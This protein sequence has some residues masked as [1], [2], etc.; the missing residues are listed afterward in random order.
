M[1]LGA[2][3]GTAWF[4]AQSGDPEPVAA[5]SPEA[6]V[7][8]AA[9]PEWSVPLAGHGS[10]DFTTGMAFASWLTDTTVIR[11]QKD[12]VLAYTLNTGKR[13]WGTPSPGDQLCGA[14]PEVSADAVAAIAY[15]TDG[16]CGQLAGLDTTTGKVTWKTVIASEKSSVSNSLAVPSIM[17]TADMAVVEVDNTLT[18][19]RL[20]DGGKA[21]T[22]SPPDSCY[23]QDANSAPDR[24][25]ILLDCHSGSNSVQVLH[26]TTGRVA[27]KYPIGDLPLTNGVLSARPIVIHRQIRGEDTFTVYASTGKVSEFSAGEADTRSLNSVALVQGGH[28][29][30][31]YAVHG[32]RLYLATKLEHMPDDGGGY[33]NKALA[34][35]IKTGRRLWESTG[36]HDTPL[37]YIRADEQ[38]LL[39]LEVGD[40]R[41]LPP[42]LVRFDPATGKAQALATLPLKYGTEADRGQV[43]ER[44]GAVIIVPWTS[45]ASKNA[46]S[47]IDTDSS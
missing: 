15:V 44:D 27:G 18:S 46:V 41:T 12:G 43:Y 42:R 33:R 8:E 38:G 6:A 17:S 31:T 4:V 21:W 22:W 34:F 19:Y 47:F 30:R 45:V 3:G 39:A 26:P 14:T 32:D 35:D 10:M 28:E 40:W 25:V 5:A 29:R 1:L 9:V 11:A 24:V 7:A 16:R 2:G 13:A 36:T 37:S 20:S 23:L